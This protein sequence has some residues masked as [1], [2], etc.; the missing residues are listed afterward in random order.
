MDLKQ[1]ECFVA[2][3]Q[4]L[5]FRRAAER[6]SMS[7]SAVSDRISTLEYTTGITL[8]FRTTRQVSLTQAGVEFLKDISAVLKEIDRSVESARR[9]AAS[10]L[11]R[12]RVSAIDEASIMLLPPTLIEFRKNW[13][14]IAVQVLEISSSDRHLQEL[15][16][17]H[18]DVAFIRKPINND[19]IISELLYQQP[20]VAIVNE[21]S[22]L[23]KARTLKVSDIAEENIIGYPKH[24]RPI[25]H[26]LIW[27]S[28]RAEN[29][30]PKITNEVIDKST[31]MQ[32]VAQNLGIGLAPQW[33]KNISP[34]GLA[35]IPFMPGDASIDMYIAYRKNGNSLTTNEF[36]CAAKEIALH[37][38]EPRQ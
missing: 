29:I 17:R 16:N 2:V 6:L 4:E 21:S 3:A 27:S 18:A 28:F 20:I 31:L 7:Q 11:N 25:L 9:V 35:F 30:Q 5:S 37:L 1:L 8:L 33:I 32:F 23:A 36:I 26:D 19:Y 22:P 10:G 14:D 34:G 12:I 15:S 13:P 38:T 24:A